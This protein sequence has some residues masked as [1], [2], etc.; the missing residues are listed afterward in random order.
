MGEAQGSAVNTPTGQHPTHNGRTRNSPAQSAV[1]S[2]IYD[3]LDSLRQETGGLSREDPNSS[4]SDP[5]DAF[6]NASTAANQV[7]SPRH[8]VFLG[9]SAG[10]T[11]TTAKHL[12][13]S[14]SQVPFLL[15]VFN[16]NV[17]SLMQAVHMPTV[18]K[19]LLGSDQNQQAALSAPEET[20]MFAIYF[21][22]VISME[23]PDVT[24]NLGSTKD[25]LTRKFRAGF[26][27]ALA[28]TNFLGAPSL[29]IV[30]ALLIFL[31]LVRCNDS[32]RF[33]WMMTGL[34]IRMAQSL[35]MNRDGS[36]SKRMSPHEV[37]M[38]RRVWWGLSFLD[39][40]TSEDMGTELTISHGTFDTKLPLNINDSD[41]S[42]EMTEFPAERQGLTDMS[43]ALYCFEISELFRRMMNPAAVCRDMDR[44]LDELYAKF[45][46]RYLR[47]EKIGE[48][49]VRY[50]IGVAVARLIVAK[51]RLM[52]HFPELLSSPEKQNMPLEI[53]DKLFLSAIEITEQNHAINTQTEIRGW[54]WISHSYTHWHAIIFVLLEMTQR[55][56][57]PTVERAWSALHSEYLIPSKSSLERGPRFWTPLRR[58]IAQARKHREA[59]LERLRK[60]P[61]TAK[62]LEEEDARRVPFANDGL[63]PDMVSAKLF[64][65]RWQGLVA[66]E[67]GD[68]PGPS[69]I[70]VTVA[71]QQAATLSTLVG[72]N[73]FSG[74][75]NNLNL[76]RQNFGCSS[77]N[78]AP[79]ILFTAAPNTQAP[80]F[81]G[82]SSLQ[83]SQDLGSNA[84]DPSQ[85]FP[86]WMGT[87]P[88]TSGDVSGDFQTSMEMDDAVDWWEWLGTANATEQA[89]SR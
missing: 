57:S 52:I 36:K 80:V 43:N 76:A 27:H 32:P 21:A 66:G 34:A 89:P 9:Q 23:E 22:A 53:R 51:T 50:W 49:S 6:R 79:N 41:I 26:E 47:H 61:A 82:A 63:F 68:K 10:L 71:A 88:G 39:A 25:E 5:E 38:R 8:T 2:R 14:S 87:G 29:I 19:L 28:K 67:A 73:D 59:E 64:R 81:S 40:R 4:D 13:P 83:L 65:E 58:L 15:T 1:I 24:G 69:N 60:D 74:L 35:G 84:P 37:E 85:G 86:A 70:A 55:Q 11:G 44:M 77:G 18:K 17:N 56:W 48:P 72:I 45:D 75:Q 78:T 46:Q 3:E 54:R 30:Q 62:S 33:V 20:L 31:F 12:Y 42:P 7:T 16:D